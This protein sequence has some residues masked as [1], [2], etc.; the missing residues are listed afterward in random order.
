MSKISSSDDENEDDEDD[1]Y[2]HD[3]R[4]LAILTAHSS[5]FGGADAHRWGADRMASL[6][7]NVLTSLRRPGRGRYDSERL[8]RSWLN[9]DGVQF[10]TSDLGPA[11][12]ARCDTQAELV[13]RLDA[14]GV[15]YDVADLPAVLAQL[16]ADD[17]LKYGERPQPTAFNRNPQRPF[18]R[19]VSRLY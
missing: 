15:E 2:V 3:L 13:E 6:A 8:L 16:E 9:E 7:S 14:D 5:W 19:Q 11:L 10:T 18:V 4:L 1:E 12:A 17:R